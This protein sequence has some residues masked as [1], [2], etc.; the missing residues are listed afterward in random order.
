MLITDE[1]EWD[2]PTFEAHVE[3]MCSQIAK[4]PSDTVS[5]LAPLSPLSVL[6]LFAIWKIGKIAS[7]L[8]PKI[9]CTNSALFTPE[10]P[11]PATP[12]SYSWDLEKTATHIRT[13]GSSGTPKIACHTFRNHV[14]SAQGSLVKIPL[15]ENSCWGLTLPLYHASGLA[16]LFRCYLSRAKILIS[17]N[18][19][20]ATHLSLV[21]TQLYRLLRDTASLPNLQTLLLGGAPLPSLQTPWNVL[22][23]YGMTEMSSQIVTDHTLHPHAEMTIASDGEIWVRGGVLFQGYL[24]KGL[25]LNSQG[26][27]ET[28]DLG[29]WKENKFHIIGRKD[30]L[31]ISGG[32]NIQ[33]EEIEDA[34]RSYCSIEEAIVIPLKDEEFGARPGVF[35][36]DPSL[37]PL[38]Q[39]KLKDVLPKFKIPIKAFRLPDNLGLKPNRKNLKAE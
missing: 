7:P 34:I 39:S 28:G 23:T 32:E 11:T 12:T 2:Y 26:W 15:T 35:L 4:H 3:G 10:M 27:F 18:Q 36:S 22:P 31:F 5:F 21:P 33:P 6:T 38:I 9:P 8:D 30:N 19:S 17:K 16:I 20:R 1:F 25:P 13:S 24:D 14:L 29:M 37:L